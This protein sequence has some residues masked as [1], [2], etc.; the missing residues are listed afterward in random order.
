LHT[1][2]NVLAARYSLVK[3]GYRLRFPGVTMVTIGSKFPSLYDSVCQIP[4]RHNK[5]C[6]LLS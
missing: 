1:F 2:C 5:I 4:Q 6:A 3:V